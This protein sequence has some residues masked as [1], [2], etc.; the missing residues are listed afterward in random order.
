MSI[1]TKK[2]DS[3]STTLGQKRRVSKSHQIIAVLGDLDELN[4]YLGW[5]RITVTRIHAKQLAKIQT[6]L[7]WLGAILAGTAKKC[8]R[9]DDLTKQLVQLETEL[10]NAERDL[11]PLTRFIL[12]AGCESACR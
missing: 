3:G 2:G 9:H 8:D 10:A 7:F 11:P 5:A 1:S 12:P 4:T 6:N